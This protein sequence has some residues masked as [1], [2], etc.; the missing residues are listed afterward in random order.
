[1]NQS[2]LQIAELEGQILLLNEEVDYLNES[3]KWFY[4]EMYFWRKKYLREHPEFDNHDYI[5]CA[6][7]IE[8][9]EDGSD[10]I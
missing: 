1:M 7:Q 3:R 5:E 2:D 8:E 6:R 9:N 4:E 10:K